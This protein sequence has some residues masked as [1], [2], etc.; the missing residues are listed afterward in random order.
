MSKTII[1][2]KHFELRSLQITRNCINMEIKSLLTSNV[3]SC[4]VNVLII[5]IFLVFP[6]SRPMQYDSSFHHGLPK[7]LSQSVLGHFGGMWMNL[8]LGVYGKIQLLSGS[9]RVRIYEKNQEIW[10]EIQDLF[11]TCSIVSRNCLHFN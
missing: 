1:D 2:V 8:P 11:S 3:C 4:D 5:L 7:S 9:I 6:D 10:K